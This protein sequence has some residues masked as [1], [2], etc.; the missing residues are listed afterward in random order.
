MFSHLKK[1][2]GLYYIIYLYIYIYIKKTS[3]SAWLF[4]KLPSSLS[5]MGC[6][7]NSN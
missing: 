3:H 2:Y 1:S 7:I 5:F 6:V 4:S